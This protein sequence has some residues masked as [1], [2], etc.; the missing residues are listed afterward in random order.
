MTLRD[1]GCDT[2]GPLQMPRDSQKCSGT[3]PRTLKTPPHLPR[4]PPSMLRTPIPVTMTGG[5][6]D[7]DGGR[8]VALSPCHPRVTEAPAGPE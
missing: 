8:V 3:L 5:E 4:T 2:Q 6:G 7:N 1:P